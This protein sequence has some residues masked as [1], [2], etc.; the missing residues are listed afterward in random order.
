MRS[1][2]PVEVSARSMGIQAHMAMEENEGLTRWVK[3]AD[4]ARSEAKS[5]HKERM[6]GMERARKKSAKKMVEPTAKMKA[7]KLVESP[8]LAR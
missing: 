4:M 2:S 8:Q 7:A 6:R 1:Q 3:Q 5:P